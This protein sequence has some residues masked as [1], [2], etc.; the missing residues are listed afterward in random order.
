MSNPAIQLLCDNNHPMDRGAD[1]CG[2]CGLPPR[3]LQDSSG[4]P[5]T[6]GDRVSWRGQIYT[7]KAF[8]ELVGRYGTRAIEFEEPLHSS[9]EVPDEIAVDLVR[10][11][12]MMPV[13][14]TKDPA[15]AMKGPPGHR[16]TCGI[17]FG[18]Y[19]AL[20]EHVRLSIACPRCGATPADLGVGELF[21]WACGHWI[22]R[23]DLS[24]A[25]RT[26]AKEAAPR[27]CCP[28]CGGDC[29]RWGTDTCP[30]RPR[31]IPRQEEP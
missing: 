21:R 18:D 31:Q 9:D 13:S 23:D 22:A 15:H 26:D 20:A 24:A 1:W 6:I 16:C 8:G 5:I 19:D 25:I 14:T 17:D 30:F 11:N 3:R 28:W 29:P 10:T 12:A 27:T 4:R 2:E 7:I